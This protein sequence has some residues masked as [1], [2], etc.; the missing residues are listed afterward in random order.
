MGL[1][2]IGNLGEIGGGAL[3]ESTL[4]VLLRGRGGPSGA[5]RLRA[6]IWTFGFGDVPCEPSNNGNT[7]AVAWRPR[8]NGLSVNWFDNPRSLPPDAIDVLELE[9]ERLP[10]NELLRARPERLVDAGKCA[11]RSVEAVL[12][13]AIAPTVSLRRWNVSDEKCNKVRVK[14]DSRNLSGAF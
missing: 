8:K 11:I 1:A 9:V 2:I 6:S 5:M 14:E 7:G 3:L 4:S 10:K 13:G 12:F